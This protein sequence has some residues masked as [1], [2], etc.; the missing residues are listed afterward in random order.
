[1]IVWK[2]LKIYTQKR[3]SGKTNN[4]F[5]SYSNLNWKDSYQ[6]TKDNPHSELL[7]VNWKYILKPNKQYSR[8]PD[9]FD[10]SNKADLN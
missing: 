1:M 9:Y 7:K 4:L 5:F 3:D 2:K 10:L 8:F 6:Q